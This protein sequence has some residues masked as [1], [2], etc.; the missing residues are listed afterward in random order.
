MS[1]SIQ[2][3]FDQLKPALQ[4]VEDRLAEHTG[5]ESLQIPTLLNSVAVKLLWSEKEIR[6]NDPIIRQFIHTHP[7]WYIARGAKGG[8]QRRSVKNKK[9]AELLARAQ[10][11]AEVSAALD[12]K[13]Q[14]TDSSSD[15]AT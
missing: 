12:A 1:N 3:F 7:D 14:K 10:A 9:D 13:M 5:E 15:D 6:V 2:S 4:L 11:K 8:A